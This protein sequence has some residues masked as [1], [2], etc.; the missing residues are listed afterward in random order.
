MSP[1]RNHHLNA[2]ILP[3][4]CRGTYPP[5][6]AFFLRSHAESLLMKDR[7]IILA[8]ATLLISNGIASA[9]T[10]ARDLPDA[11]NPSAAGP[12]PNNAS[13]ETADRPPSSAT[14][15]D[16]TAPI[17]GRI[18]PAPR[19]C[20]LK[21][22]ASAGARRPPARRRNE[23][24]IVQHGSRFIGRFR[25]HQHKGRCGATPP[26]SG[27]W[28]AQP[29]SGRKERLIRVTTASQERFSS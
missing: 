26:H 15:P 9:Q 11:A 12:A 29:S 28:L 1:L 6:K 25:M 3:L 8:T 21:W 17:A 10:P 18:P 24:R 2:V 23:P 4:G 16:A 13:T 20:S 22:T 19:K 14:M 7:C 27:T 5:R